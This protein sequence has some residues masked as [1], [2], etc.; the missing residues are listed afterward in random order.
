MTFAL[1]ETWAF[2][3]VTI[4][5]IALLLTAPFFGHRMIPMRVRVGL[6]VGIAAAAGDRFGPGVDPVGL[7]AISIVLM[8]GREILIGALL[9]FASSLIF[10]G[11]ALMGEIASIQGGLGAATVLDPTSG[12]SSVVL[13]SI[14][15]LFGL[16]IF[17]AIDGHHDMIRGVA[18]SFSVYPVG[19]QGFPT[20][21]LHAVSEM[22]G[23]I[24]RVAVHLAAPITAA[25]IISNVAVGILG[26]A[27][28]QLNLMA[29]QLPAHV[30][31]TLLILG[32]GA[33]PLTD[34]ISRNLTSYTHQA[35]ESVLGVR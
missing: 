10:S 21:S 28:P 20:D 7:D 5:L 1:D 24:F 18:L 12:S 32:V 13:T 9:G 2:L 31:T 19:A 26:R 23:V 8:V 33:G 35:I 25:M 15:Q 11:L 34:S 6:A 22:G 30:A 4:R 14:V 3:L 17:L 29:L 16:M 27:I